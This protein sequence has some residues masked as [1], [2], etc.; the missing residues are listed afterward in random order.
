MTA[1]YILTVVAVA[2][3]CTF[4]L[5]ALPFFAFA[6]DRKMPAWLEK[7][8]QTLP[9][10]IMAVLIVYCLKDAGNDLIHVGIPKFIA[11]AVVAASYRWRHSTLLSIVL[12][13]GAYMLLLLADSLYF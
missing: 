3:A 2:A 5:R 12:G 9:A 13:T 1:T 10:A 11:V 6:G 7:L 4:A 8:G